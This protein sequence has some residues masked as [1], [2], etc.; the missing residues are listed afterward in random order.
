MDKNGRTPVIP[1]VVRGGAGE[2]VVKVDLALPLAE[3]LSVFE[4]AARNEFLLSPGGFERFDLCE[5]LRLRG[6]D[7]RLLERGVVLR[8]GFLRSVG[9]D[10]AS[11]LLSSITQPHTDL[12]VFLLDSLIFFFVSLLCL[13]PH[14]PSPPAVKL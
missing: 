10:M 7:V 13:C 12:S 6:L 4:R 8:E 9:L 11:P 1:G 14:V 3:R 5:D 2:Q